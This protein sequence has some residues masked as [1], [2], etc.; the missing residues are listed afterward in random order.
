MQRSPDKHRLYKVTAADNQHIRADD[1]TH[2]K[3][4]LLNTDWAL[5]LGG[6]EYIVVHVDGYL[7]TGI[8]EYRFAAKSIGRPVRWRITNREVSL[9]CAGE[10]IEAP[11]D[12]DTFT[13]AE[14]DTKKVATV[15]GRYPQP[16]LAADI[17]PDVLRSH[18]G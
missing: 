15:P 9:L 1:R 14:T 8:P 2:F 5:A 10:T 16:G 6:G 3:G 11:M 7:V 12:L 13:D 4:R 17:D 18:S